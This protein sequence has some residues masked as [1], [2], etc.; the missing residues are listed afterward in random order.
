MRRAEIYRNDI[1][2]GILTETD[3]GTYVFTY[4]SMYFNDNTKPGIS[5]T[6]T[7]KQSVYNSGHL[8]PF[9]YNML[10]EGTNRLVQAKQL[11][12]DE[13]DFFGLLLAT[14]QYDTIG[15]IT[16]KQIN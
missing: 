7:K 11:K 1:L 13:N 12:I 5:L 15:A 8:F 3:S 16:V 10:S 9:F 14:A 2:A 4:D 6:L